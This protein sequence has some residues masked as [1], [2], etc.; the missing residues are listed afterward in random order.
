MLIITYMTNVID[1]VFHRIIEHDFGISEF[2]ANMKR[3]NEILENN[4]LKEEK[5]GK[6][7]YTN[8]L[9]VVEL[10]DVSF[11]YQKSNSQIIE[12]INF[13]LEANSKNAIVGESGT[14]KSTI[15]NYY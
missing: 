10:E 15:F 9:G 12:N 13:K 1:D 2:T 14:G 4:N 7:N 5:F 6:E 11:K 8:I 3:I